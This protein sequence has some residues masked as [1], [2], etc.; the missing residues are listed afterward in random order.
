MM[1][2]AAILLL[3]LSTML[4]VPTQ[5]LSC[6]FPSDGPFTLNSMLHAAE[7]AVVI[8]I[9]KDI[10]PPVKPIVPQEIQ[11]NVGNA[12]HPVYV[13]EYIMPP[14]LGGMPDPKYY[15]A[16]VQNVIKGGYG[17]GQII[18]RGGIPCGIGSLKVA[19]TYLLFGSI[20][21]QEVTGYVGSV[22]VFY[23]HGIPYVHKPMIEY[24]K[25][26]QKKIWAYGKGERTCEPQDCP[27]NIMFAVMLCPDKVSTA[28]SSA[29]CAY[30]GNR[31]AYKI[32]E[33]TCPACKSDTDCKTGLVCGPDG[34]CSTP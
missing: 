13:T 30:D 22:P 11:V 16:A 31:C 6:A 7:V 3:L 34:L 29:V 24:S 26:D 1:I 25:A 19:T 12:T 27:D 33:H 18:V 28:G 2:I 15:T 9:N 8:K 5:S 4:V 21:N 32:T 23:P 14:M 17:T 10:T 20:Q